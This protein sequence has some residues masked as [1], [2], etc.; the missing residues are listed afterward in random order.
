MTPVLGYQTR[1]QLAYMETLCRRYRRS[2]LSD[3]NACLNQYKWGYE[4]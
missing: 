2:V 1:E 3:L 4:V